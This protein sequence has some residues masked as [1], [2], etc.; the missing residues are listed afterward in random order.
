ME[1]TRG[2]ID[3]AQDI[4]LAFIEGPFLWQSS[5]L[6]REGPGG[7]SSMHMGPQRSTS[8]KWPCFPGTGMYVPGVTVGVSFRGSPWLVPDEVGGPAANRAA[9]RFEIRWFGSVLGRPSP[10]R[11]LE[12]FDRSDPYVS[13]RAVRVVV[14]AS[15]QSYRRFL[16]KG[17]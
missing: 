1:A 9:F 16:S 17:E 4:P 15:K 10:T 14:G 13:V 7:G 3:R 12:R 5:I 8:A 6:R 2:A 11:G